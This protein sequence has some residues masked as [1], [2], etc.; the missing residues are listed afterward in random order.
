MVAASAPAPA[1]PGDISLFSLEVRRLTVASTTSKR[2]RLKYVLADSAWG[3]DMCKLAGS[4][5][6]SVRLRKILLGEAYRDKTV[7]RRPRNEALVLEF[8]VLQAV[9]SLSIEDSADELLLCIFSSKAIRD[10]IGSADTT[11]TASTA[12]IAA[13][14]A[15]TREGGGRDGGLSG[16]AVGGIV[17]GAST[18]LLFVII[19]V[20]VYLHGWKRREHRDEEEGGRR[21]RASQSSKSMKTLA[22]SS[23]SLCGSGKVTGGLEEDVTGVEGG[24]YKDD[25]YFNEVPSVTDLDNI[26][27]PSSAT[28]D[29]A[30]DLELLFTSRIEQSGSLSCRS[31][32]PSI[33][34]HLAQ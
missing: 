9:L 30:I 20:C 26:T 25:E 1:V 3:G 8:G 14:S 17:G 32:P 2:E 27:E 19:C 18:A 5:T 15:A 31:I 7:Y 11:G 21:A 28:E 34:S 23:F 29:R 16:G 24:T 22:L 10:D 13:D 6:R 12:E 33:Q 4:G